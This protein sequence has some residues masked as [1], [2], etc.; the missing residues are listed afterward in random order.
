MSPSLCAPST[1]WNFEVW[2]LGMPFNRT[3]AEENHGPKWSTGIPHVSSD[4]YQHNFYDPGL[5]LFY[6]VCTD[7]EFLFYE[8]HPNL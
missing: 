7:S 3:A 1:V 2:N 8:W 6:K 5:R 4:I